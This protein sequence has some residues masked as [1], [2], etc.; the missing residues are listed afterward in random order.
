MPVIEAEE[1][2]RRYGD[3]WGLKNATFT[4]GKGELVVLAGPNGAGK[5]TTVKIL[6]TNLKPSKGGAKVLGMD[7][8][9]EYKSI[10]RRICY[11]PQEYE[12]SRDLKPK[13]A[14]MWNLVAR[15]WPIGEARAQARR[16]LKLLG[17]WELRD[18]RC[19]TLSGGEKRR[20]AV[21]VIL[22]SEAEL[23][24]LD[25]P[26]VGL[27]VEIKHRVWKVIR[28]L[29]SSG[30]SILLTT[31]DMSEAETI[32]DK[33][34]M[35]NQGETV[36][37]EQPNRLVSSLPYGYKVVVE[38][39]DKLANTDLDESID[40]GDRLILYAKGRN[41]AVGLVDELSSVTSMHSMGEVTLEDAYLYVVRRGNDG[42][43]QDT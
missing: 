11:L 26:T 17:I 20:V 29:I 1:L 7:L 33:V 28:E 39:S 2:G 21:A 42:L 9:R 27:D 19:W 6:N 13:E 25:E 32:A 30:T 24:F 37:E 41:E 34:V 12:V 8:G 22:S 5:T 36:A 35:I 18:R 16:W 31:H 43:H 23:I 4:V 10:R 15:G 38:K 40:L 14:V 3:T